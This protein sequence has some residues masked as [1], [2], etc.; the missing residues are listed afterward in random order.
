MERLGHETDGAEDGVQCVEKVID[1]YDAKR[2]Y[3]VL[4][5]DNQMPRME[6]LEVLKILRQRYALPI[7]MLTGSSDTDQLQEFRS[8]GA[9]DILLKPATL[10][11]IDTALRKVKG[12][13]N[14]QSLQDGFD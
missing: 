9:D 2:P 4:F 10:N 1:A 6:G 11:M 12:K 14:A 3:D 8:V 13:Q 7:I 5:L